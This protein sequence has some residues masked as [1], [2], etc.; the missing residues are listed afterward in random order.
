MPPSP[1][2]PVAITDLTA[3]Q[4]GDGVMLDFTMP[5]KS[6]CGEKLKDVPT[7]EVLRGALA[8]GWND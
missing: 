4:A 8:R 6:V 1:P 7:M 2:I 3:Q 5:G